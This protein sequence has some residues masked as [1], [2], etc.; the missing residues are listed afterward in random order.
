MSKHV[1][2]RP[3]ISEKSEIMSDSQNKYSFVVARDANKIEIKNAVQAK[4]EVSVTAVNTVIMPSKAK[5]RNTKSGLIKGRKSSYKKAIVTVADGET[6]DY[7][8][9]E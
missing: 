6:L 1:L 9:G 2:I 4:F 3:I 8:G 7:F 5:S